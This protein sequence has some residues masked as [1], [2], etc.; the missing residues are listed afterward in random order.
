MRHRFLQ[1]V[2]VLSV[3]A[4][5]CTSQDG[6]S[7]E[8]LPAD[9]LL[10]EVVT[11]HAF[12]YRYHERRTTI[13]ISADGFGVV[14]GATTQEE[15]QVIKDAVKGGGHPNEDYPHLVRGI[16][17]SKEDLK[18]IQQEFDRTRLRSL[19]GEYGSPPPSY[20]EFPSDRWYM[21]VAG[22]GWSATMDVQGDFPM[23][24]DVN[25]ERERMEHA[26]HV[27]RLMQTV[28]ALADESLTAEVSERLKKVETLLEVPE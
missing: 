3:T 8:P 11:I 10:Q 18:G 23:G 12:F 6:Q 22:D 21:N 24:V 27:L 1:L 26:A 16:R 2:V 9:R 28:A 17:L 4:I 7:A 19:D 13:S 15:S 14:I 25:Q 5:C 20:S